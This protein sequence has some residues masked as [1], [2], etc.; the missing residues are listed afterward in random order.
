M[1][2]I[3]LLFCSLVLI[4]SIFIVI[5][6]YKN[7]DTKPKDKNINRSNRD[8]IIEKEQKANLIVNT[9]E[10]ID[11]ETN[12]KYDRDVFF[13][14]DSLTFYC[15]DVLQIGLSDFVQQQQLPTETSL[16]AINNLYEYGSTELISSNLFEWRSLEVFLGANR[17][18]FRSFGERHASFYCVWSDLDNTKYDAVMI[19]VCLQRLSDLQVFYFA[20]FNQLTVT[21][22][23]LKHIM[24]AFNTLSLR[25]ADK[26]I[27]FVGSFGIPITYAFLKKYWPFLNAHHICNLDN[28]PTRLSNVTTDDIIIS[29]Y[30]YEYV[31]YSTDFKK[32]SGFSQSLV[33]NLDMYIKHTDANKCS[34][35]K[36][37][38]LSLLHAHKEQKSNE[39]DEYENNQKTLEIMFLNQEISAKLNIE[40]DYI[41]P[42]PSAPSRT[43]SVS[44]LLPSYKNLSI[45]NLNEINSEF[46]STENIYEKNNLYPNL[47]VI[48]KK[49]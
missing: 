34:P 14:K 4:I 27:L 28:M 37:W 5:L 35:T 6:I 16:M 17:K 49:V 26:P 43:S 48:N 39:T 24:Q 45:V 38:K 15:A 33:L 46:G 47:N 7:N 20:Q 13:N 40:N 18:K 23:A 31:E 9:L 21:D 36:N 10:T 29:N 42:K 19:V 44:T 22:N 1:I 11:A 3:L 2:N 25:H 12:T 30:L 32:T 41:R 8:T